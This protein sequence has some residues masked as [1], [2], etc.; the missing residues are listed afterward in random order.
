MISPFAGALTT[1]LT[2]ASGGSEASDGP[3]EVD[4]VLLFVFAELGK[5][6]A[7]ASLQHPRARR[8]LHPAAF[9]ASAVDT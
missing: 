9:P 2:F 5:T 7:R 4:D 6:A 3:G 1:A 8:V